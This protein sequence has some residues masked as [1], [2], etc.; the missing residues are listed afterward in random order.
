MVESASG[1][2]PA[3]APSFG[4]SYPRTRHAAPSLPPRPEGLN[5]QSS[6]LTSGQGPAHRIIYVE[7]NPSNVAF[8]E[9]LLGSFERVALLTAP[10][11]EIGIELVRAH[12]PA[13]VIMD[14]N[15]PGMSGFE[16]L[17]QLREWPETR[18]IPVVAL[19]AAAMPRETKRGEQAGFVRYLTKPVKVDELTSLLETL[20]AAAPKPAS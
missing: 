13:V 17:R 5:Q 2:S 9:A 1:A 18:D 14:I 16:A 19:S 7:D 6:P 8:M 3:R 12:Q 4:W 20:L 11:A 15:L 10:T